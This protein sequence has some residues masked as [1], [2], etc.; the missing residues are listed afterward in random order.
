MS[1]FAGQH[2]GAS[3]KSTEAR[4]AKCDDCCRRSPI[5][6]D[7]FYSLNGIKILGAR[8][9]RTCL[10]NPFFAVYNRILLDL[11][12]SVTTTNYNHFI[13]F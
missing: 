1:S 5:T 2:P 12:L 11:Y 8:M 7:I 13:W 10:A 4:R 9:R 6:A 3:S